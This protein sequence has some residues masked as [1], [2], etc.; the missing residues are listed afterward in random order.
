MYKL[1][2]CYI[3][4]NNVI[5]SPT[6]ATLNLKYHLIVSLSS[7]SVSD[8]FNLDFRVSVVVRNIL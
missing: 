5:R 4:F 3:L 1:I 8:G 6:P 7:V 2:I